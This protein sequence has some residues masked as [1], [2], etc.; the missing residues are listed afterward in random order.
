L[1]KEDTAPRLRDIWT[2]IH[3]SL[4]WSSLDVDYCDTIL[5]RGIQQAAE[6]SLG[7]YYDVLSKKQQEKV[8]VQISQQ[9]SALAVIRLFKR[10]QRENNET[11]DR[12]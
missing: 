6:Q 11:D 7:Y 2:E 4:N 8:A 12:E 5:L 10:K 9:T 1:D 3:A